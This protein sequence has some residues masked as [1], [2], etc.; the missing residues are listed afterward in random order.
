MIAVPR[1]RRSAGIPLD[2]VIFGQDPEQ[3]SAGEGRDALV[4]EPYASRLISS[5]YAE[6]VSHCLDGAP[7]G[8]EGIEDLDNFGFRASLRALALDAQA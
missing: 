6:H 1:V 5:E 4:I 2:S 8:L 3:A 7:R